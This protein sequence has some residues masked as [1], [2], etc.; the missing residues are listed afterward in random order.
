VTEKVVDGSI[1]I[2]C[3]KETAPN[4]T[5]SNAHPFNN[6]YTLLA[7]D[8][9]IFTCAQDLLLQVPVKVQIKHE[10]VKVHFRSKKQDTA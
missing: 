6:P 8:I 7:A 1:T 3:D 2:Y 10:W 5:F 4:Q 9:N